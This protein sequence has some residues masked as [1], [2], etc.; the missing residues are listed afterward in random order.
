M[1]STHASSARRAFALTASALLMLTAGAAAGEPDPQAPQIKR[2]LADFARS[3]G[4]EAHFVEEKHMALLAAPLKAEGTIYFTP[5]GSLARHTT[6]P[7]RSRLLITP[8]QVIFADDRGTETIALGARPVVRSF[9]ESFVTILRGDYD[10]LDQRYA[11]TLHIPKEA[12]QW[13]LVLRPRTGPMARVFDRLEVH[14]VERHVEAFI[15]HER[16]GDRT[17]TR[18]TA[19]NSMRTF[20]DEERR[21]LFAVPSVAP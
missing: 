8:S 14:G 10:S 15:A 16:D 18:F 17:V 7:A 13:R 5:P 20:T 3:T 2:L 19:V 21:T 9:V 11:M 6:A 12:G 4:I 1:R